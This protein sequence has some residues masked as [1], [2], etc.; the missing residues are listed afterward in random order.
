M[1]K[2][3]RV[4]GTADENSLEMQK[5]KHE[6]T[7][8]DAATSPDPLAPWLDYHKWVKQ[9]YPNARQ[10]HLTV[11]QNAT[12][13]FRD[14]KQYKQDNRYLRLWVLY[15]S[16]IIIFFLILHSFPINN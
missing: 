16:K 3:S 15:V 14:S 6:R 7:I 9:T 10:E 11:L 13:L 5:Q 8:K 4:K 2:T 12:K 1:M